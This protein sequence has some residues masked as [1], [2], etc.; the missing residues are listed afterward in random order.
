[1]KAGQKKQNPK[2]GSSLGFYFKRFAC[3]QQAVNMEYRHHDYAI[4]RNA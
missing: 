2:G 3:D 4:P 1:M